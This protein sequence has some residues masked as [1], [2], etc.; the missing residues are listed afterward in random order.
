MKKNGF[1]IVEVL[2]GI[3]IIVTVL[4]VI[5][6]ILFSS[7]S[8]SNKSNILKEARQAGSYAL[9]IMEPIIRGASNITC[10]Q[11]SVTIENPRGENT[12]FSVIN[13]RIASGSAD[14]YYLTTD[15][16][17]VSNFIVTCQ[18]NPGNPAKV[19]ISFDV[20]KTGEYLRS[21]ESVLQNFKTELILRN[22]K[23]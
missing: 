15:N 9:E 22:Y 18:S 3:V 23:N 14:K 10:S 17:I 13:D 20:S 4:V 11:D 8:S 1:S 16:L 2:I 6:N 19:E 7:F 5:F 21:S 12:T